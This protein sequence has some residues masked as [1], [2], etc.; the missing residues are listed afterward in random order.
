MR[1][2]IYLLLVVL[3][4]SVAGC[5]TT[6][7][8]K[9]LRSELSQKME[10]KMDAKLAVVDA[11]L[12]TLK[13]NAAVT[14]AL[15]KGQADA[16]AD[17]TDL[18]ENL[19]QLRGQVETLKKDSALN[20]KKD[21]QRFDN[22]L[23]KI[24]FIENFLEIGNKNTSGDDRGSKATGVSTAKDPA[25]KQDKEKAYSAAYQIFKE[26]NYDK[27]R[28]EFQNFL[29]A[30]PDSEYSDNAQFWVGE[31]Y[32]FE[33]KYETAILEYEKVTKNYPNGNKVPYAL[34]KQGI[35]FLKLGDKTSAKL[36]LQQ[37]I[38]NYPNTSQAR[39][40]RSSLQEIK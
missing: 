27:A 25:K 28:T 10:E 14:E 13:K 22:I 26:G 38:K 5:A 9:A 31:C 39:I 34:L 11:D 15:R 8:L 30:Y 4:F 35:S 16:S 29:T 1:N 23:L 3:V 21:E 7:D 17:I 18:R 32:F 36:L 40:A 19:Q 12:A 6:Q 20:T 2:S 24:N 37:V 33:Q